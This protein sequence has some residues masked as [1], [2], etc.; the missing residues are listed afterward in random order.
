MKN[1]S[2]IFFQIGEL[3]G[4][5]LAGSLAIMCDAAHLLSDCAGFLLALSA[6]FLARRPPS[7]RMS[8]GYRRAGTYVI[9]QKYQN[10]YALFLTF[11][12]VLRFC[13][14]DRRTIVNSINLA[15]HGYFCVLG[16]LA[17]VGRELQHTSE[18]D[19]DRFRRRN[20]C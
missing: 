13:R 18:R 10:I 14:S 15:R 20:D 9:K 7:S 19:D 6:L 2:I 11:R 5:Y 17:I 4:G 16:H 3:V 12:F 1:V 8:F